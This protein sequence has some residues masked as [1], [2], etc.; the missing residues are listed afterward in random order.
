MI[1][2][3]LKVELSQEVML[4]VNEGDPS[5]ASKMQEVMGA[6]K[7]GV[8][9]RMMK[10]ERQEEAKERFDSHKPPKIN[11]GYMEDIKEQD[12]EQESNRA[13]VRKDSK[14]VPTPVDGTQVQTKIKQLTEKKQKLQ[15]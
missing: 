6:L 7:G 15:A 2:Y 3:K 13:S 9:D 14:V 5:A 8:V 1:Q 10:D 11:K 12:S 4:K